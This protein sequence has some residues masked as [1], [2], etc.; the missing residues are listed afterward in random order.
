[1]R[2]ARKPPGSDAMTRKGN[3]SAAFA[4]VTMGRLD[5][6]DADLI[7][8]CHGMSVSDIERMIAERKARE[9]TA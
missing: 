1:M 7:A 6:L 3:H 4:A 8:R 2:F 5:K 9:G